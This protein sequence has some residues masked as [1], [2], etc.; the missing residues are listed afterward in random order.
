MDNF[1][2]IMHVSQHRQ[3]TNQQFP[4]QCLFKVLTFLALIANQLRKVCSFY[5]FHNNIKIVFFNKRL[6]KFD[7]IRVFEFFIYLHF[8]ELLMNLLTRHLRNLNS[9]QSILIIT[10]FGKVNTS[11]STL[12]NLFNKAITA[13]YLKLKIFIFDHFGQLFILVFNIKNLTVIKFFK[14]LQTRFVIFVI[15]SKMPN[16]NKLT[17]KLS[18]EYFFIDFPVFLQ[19]TIISQQPKE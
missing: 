6:I 3:K 16:I 18:R 7:Y 17:Q 14:G 13:N 2:F 12:A 4:N 5:N 11:E 9:F 15:F 10:F 19:R 8:S 1:L